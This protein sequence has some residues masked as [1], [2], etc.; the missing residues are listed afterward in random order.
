MK[1]RITGCVPVL[2]NYFCIT[3]VELLSIHDS[4]SRRDGMGALECHG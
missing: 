4:Q 2:I 3:V 1:E